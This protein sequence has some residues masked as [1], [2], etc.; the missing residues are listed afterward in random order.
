LA[1][2]LGFFTLVAVAFAVYY[3]TRITAYYKRL[4]INE[5]QET[6]AYES[7][8]VEKIISEMERNAID[9]ALAG[10]QFYRF[11]K[12]RDSIGAMISVE[13][14]TAFSNAVGGGIWFEPYVLNPNKRRTCYYA[15]FDSKIGAVRLDPEFETESYDYL[16]Q[17]WYTTIIARLN[18]KNST[19]WTAPYIDDA[20][21][22]AL[23]TTV[24]AGI[25]DENGRLIG[26]STVDWKIQNMVDRLSAIKPTENSFVLLTSP[27]D[28]YVI[29]KSGSF[30]EKALKYME[31]SHTMNNG[32]VFSVQIPENEIFKEIENRIK[33]FSIIMAASAIFML[34]SVLFLL[35]KLVNK[36]LAKEQAEK[37]RM[38]AE[39]NV[40]TCIQASM[41]P[42]IFPPFP[43]KNEFDIY[44]TMLPAKEVGGDFYDFFLI[45]ENTLCIVIA[46]VS[47]KGVP[48]ALFMVIAKTLIKNNA[49]NSK[50]P[51]EVFETVN[52]QLCESNEASMF[53]TAFMGYFNISSGKFTFVNAGHNPPILH[54]SGNYSYLKMKRGF[55]LAGMEDAFYA[56]NEITL[57]KGDVLLLYTDGVTEAMNNDGTLFGE[58]RLLGA[59]KEYSDLPLKEFTTEIKCKID[60]FAEGVPQ[61]DDITM[62]AL[63]YKI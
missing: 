13:N 7:E 8:R 54:S 17:K 18:G 9:L 48:A 22:N 36:P 26:M 32:W 1:I 55:V 46:D 34:C 63:R 16:S 6:V 52:N 47:G 11:G 24:G 5:V 19:A 45:D 53:V 38:G 37:E 14:F 62:L 30:E 56:Q 43:H 44:A 50:S 20:G 40:A 25:Y 39:L 27:K 60:K 51:K 23:M 57:Q 3:Y 33:I 15:F 2:V 42:C 41:L 12:G 29:S 58:E 35:S 10:Y 28:N 21:T 59:V 4:R 61:A 49:Q 31:F